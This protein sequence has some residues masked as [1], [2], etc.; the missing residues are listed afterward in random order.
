MAP[1]RDGTTRRRLRT[2]FGVG[3]MTGLTD[4][5]L[6]ERF[7]AGRGE[8]AELAFAALIERHGPMVLRTCRA[9]L[10]GDHEAED[11]FQATFLVLVVKG[12][13]LWVEDSIGP[14][15]HRVACRIAVRARLAAD[16]R[17]EAERRAAEMAGSSRGDE[18]REE[19]GPILHAEIDRLPSR[20]RIPVVLCDLEGRTHEEAARH[21]GCPTGTIKSRLARG[22]ERLRGRLIR[23]GLAPAVGA[24]GTV[25]IAREVPAALV[26]STSRAAAARALAAGVVPV[27]VTEMTRGALRAMRH[28]MIMRVG[29]IV[30]VVGLAAAGVGRFAPRASGGPAVESQGKVAPAEPG[31]PEP[32]EQPDPEKKRLELAARRAHQ[33]VAEIE[34]EA[35][36]EW[37]RAAMNRL[38]QLELQ[39]MVGVP[40][41]GM[42]GVPRRESQDPEER[43]K[44][45]QDLEHERLRL[46]EYIEKMKDELI[47]KGISIHVKKLEL[48]E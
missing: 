16:R 34:Y 2:L 25:L 12:G 20:Y 7:A 13:S 33:E 26:E 37:L 47:H 17:R 42:V 35:K 24:F 30:L 32:K 41:L 48:Q 3:S 29:G 39:G 43:R 21:L 45:L 28:S 14:W 46:S 38:G 9:I 19:L 31:P 44:A 22:R 23:R 8:G 1:E 5:Q 11:A 6:L 18:D 40:R 10:R 15:L 27:S 4:G 36:K